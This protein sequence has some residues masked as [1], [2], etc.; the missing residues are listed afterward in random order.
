MYKDAKEVA[1]QIRQVLKKRFPQ[2]KFSVRLQR[3]GV[4]SAIYIRWVDGPARQIIKKMVY[5]Y[6]DVAY[7]EMTGEILAGGNRYV[8]AEREYSLEAITKA[9]QHVAKSM[10]KYD[11]NNFQHR[12][13]MWRW[14]EQKSF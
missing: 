9:K 13:E 6:E 10:G 11:D 8:F 3:T 5:P 7:D 12:Q 1:K 2:N 4:S 14:L